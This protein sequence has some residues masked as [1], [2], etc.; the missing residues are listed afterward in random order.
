MPTEITFGYDRTW[1]KDIGLQIMNEIIYWNL[2]GQHPRESF[3]Q[4]I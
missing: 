1:G 4:R 2:R 3:R